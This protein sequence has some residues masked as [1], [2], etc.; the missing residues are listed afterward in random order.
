MLVVRGTRRSPDPGALKRLPVG[1]LWIAALGD[2]V[3]NDAPRVV[4]E[5]V[6]WSAAGGSLGA[7]CC[8]GSRGSFA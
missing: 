1:A 3:A 6:A 8:S 2:W 5:P 4:S 7:V